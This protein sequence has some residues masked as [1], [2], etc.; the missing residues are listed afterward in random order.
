[1][2]KNYDFSGWA[3]KND[4]KCAD[5][6]TI[7]KDAFKHCDGMTVPLVWNH[8][9]KEQE[10]V[11]GHAK[12]ENRNEGVYCY[13]SFNETERGQNAKLLVQHGDIVGLS[14][15]ANHLKQ[16]PN[17]DVLHGA[18]R[19]VSL[20]LAG[21]NPGAY[22]DTVL[23]HSEEGTDEEGYIYSGESLTLAHSE[24]SETVVETKDA[25]ENPEQTENSKQE[26]SL[27]HKEGD[28]KMADQAKKNPVDDAIDSMTEDQKNAMYFI[29]AKAV[30]EA[31]KGTKE[32]NTAE[33]NKEMT[34]KHN[35][36]ENEVVTSQN[37][38]SHADMEAIINDAKRYGSMRESALQ[39]GITDIEYLF[40]EHKNVNGAAPTF[41]RNQPSEWVKVVMNGVKH[42]PFAKIKMMFADIREDEARAKGFL[43][44]NKKKEEVFSLLKRTVDPTTVYKLQKMH[45][46]DQI[47]ITDFDVVAWLKGEMRMMLDEE[48]ARAFLYGDG[49]LTSSDEHIDATKIIPACSDASLYTIEKTV[50]VAQGQNPSDALIDACVES[51][52]DYQGSGNVTGFFAQKEITKMLLMKDTLGRRL[53]KNLGELADAMLLDKIVKVPANIVPAGIKGLLLDLADYNVGADK[54]GAVNMFEDFDIDYNKNA[55]LIETR[56]SGALVKPFSAVTLK[57]ASE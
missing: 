27:E 19:E 31:K 5:G 34:I 40:P 52:D 54:G 57:E 44:G 9:H 18:I 30:E 32:E 10:S 21:A 17:G 11:L 22:I 16:T 51:L 43:K 15:Y 14:I 28:K 45:R 41:I 12:L 48:L 53:Y 46:D 1:M 23:T 20:V 36:F 24:E 35:V 3:T 4:L 55:Y 6:R 26:E 38:L 42:T 47:D 50:T 29:V 13:C 49:R 33:D 8:D 7:R 2:A 25:N 56:C 39:H 37:T